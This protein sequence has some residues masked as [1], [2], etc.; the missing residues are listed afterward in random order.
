MAAAVEPAKPPPMI[1]ISV[2]FTKNSGLVA[3]VLRSEWQREARAGE[4]WNQGIM[5]RAVFT[6]VKYATRSAPKRAG[7]RHF[8]FSD[9]AAN[10]ES[11]DAIGVSS[12]LVLLDLAIRRL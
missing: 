9:F 10:A 11:A 5:F 6:R 2:C 8:G 3:H 1:A 7:H 12:V 4:N